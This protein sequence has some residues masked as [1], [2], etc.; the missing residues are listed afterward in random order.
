MR[1]LLLEAIDIVEKG[2]EPRG[3]RPETYRHVRPHDN[4]VPQG[5]DWRTQF[6]EELL[7]KW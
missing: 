7:A 6:K 3:V 4:M 1:R 5:A 2:G